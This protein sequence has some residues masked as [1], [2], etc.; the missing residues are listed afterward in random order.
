MRLYK[1]LY[2]L[3]YSLKKDVLTYMNEMGTSSV[4]KGSENQHDKKNHLKHEPP[5]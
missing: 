1:K 2:K 4:E 3:L 5:L